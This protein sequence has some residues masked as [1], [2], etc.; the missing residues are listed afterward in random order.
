MTKA[1]ASK[2]ALACCAV[3]TLASSVWLGLRESKLPFTTLTDELRLPFSSLPLPTPSASEPGAAEGNEVLEARYLT[4]KD[5]PQSEGCANLIRLALNNTPADGRLWLEYAKALTLEGDAD[6]T[7]MQALQNSY[8]FSPREAWIAN[9][10][11]SF[12]LSIW[13]G[14]P[15]ELKQVASDEIIAELSDNR[16]REQLAMQYVQKPFTRTAIEQVMTTAPADMQI[17]FLSL[18][19]HAA[20]G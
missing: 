6:I 10:R 17:R 12:A 5:Q 15:A 16:F 2:T 11:S 20:A 7:A 18:L 13:G 14:L 8:R 9:P 19:K 4:C 1:F 3:L